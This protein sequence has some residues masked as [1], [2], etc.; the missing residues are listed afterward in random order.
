[1]KEETAKIHDEAGE[2]LKVPI[3]TWYKH[4]GLRQLYLMMPILFL[5]KAPC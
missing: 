1:M 4:G 2:G 5:G 3:V